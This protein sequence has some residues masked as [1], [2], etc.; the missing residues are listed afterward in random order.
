MQL[1]PNVCGMLMDLWAAAR[2]LFIQKT[3][4][5]NF[6]QAIFQDPLWQIQAFLN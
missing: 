4:K 2:K 5:I 3:S 6:L 1:L